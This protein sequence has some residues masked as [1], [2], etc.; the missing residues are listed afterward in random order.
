MYQKMAWSAI[1]GKRGPLVLQT[2]YAPVQ[3]NTRAARKWE[4]M[5]RGVGGKGMGDFWDSIGNVKEENT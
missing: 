3:G 2:L 1:S 5:G 4:R